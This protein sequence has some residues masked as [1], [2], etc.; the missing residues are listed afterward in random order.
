MRER[1]IAFT[2]RIIGTP[3][4]ALARRV[5]DRFGAVDG[6]LLAAGI[7]Y[8]AVL[9]LIPLALLATGFAGVILSDPASRADLVRV[10]AG[11]MPPLA[12][13]VDEIVAG[14]SRASPSI[15]LVGLVL[16]AWG[17]SRL[18]A[19]LEAAIALLD[20][21]VPR[22]SLIRRTARRL[23]SIAVIAVVVLATLAAA[24][25]LAIAVEVSDASAG[26]RPLLDALLAFV[27]PV[28]GAAALAAVYRLV[29]AARPS[30][31]SIAVPAVVGSV[32]LVVVTRVF[33]FVAPRVF[34]ANLVYGTLGALL[35]GLTWLD[36]AFTVVLLGAAWVG[37][38][39]VAR[40]GTAGAG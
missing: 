5:L 24:P 32:A 40:E 27:P 1:L 13:V 36:L 23:G 19:A 15:S 20:P 35:V 12:G 3:R 22:R 28:L 34:G 30:W 29:P 6:G 7:A 4:V 37:E 8:N 33:V 16:A 18:Y 31:R 38:R 10:L 17:T 26:L 25:L 21:S 9:A 11:V 39:E 14:L 2:T